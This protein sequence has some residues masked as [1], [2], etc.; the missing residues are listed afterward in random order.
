MFSFR[1]LSGHS[2]GRGCGVEGDMQMASGCAPCDRTDYESLVIGVRQLGEA[3]VWR[4]A[5][6]LCRSGLQR[7]P[8]AVELLRLLAAALLE[9]GEVWEARRNI[10]HAVSFAPTNSAV[11]CTFGMVLLR[12]GQM[13]EAAD[14]FAHCLRLHPGVGTAD[15]SSI[16]DLAA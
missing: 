4:D 14:V 13:E 12:C 9:T 8:R 5:V 7:W 1:G 2:R 11:L 16:G 6:E 3:G 15:F 10:G